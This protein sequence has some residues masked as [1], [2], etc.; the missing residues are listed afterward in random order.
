[1]YLLGLQSSRLRVISPEVMSPESWV[2]LP[3]ILVM[4]P[5]KEVKSLEETK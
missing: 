5:E 1:M 4:S 3:K 2:M